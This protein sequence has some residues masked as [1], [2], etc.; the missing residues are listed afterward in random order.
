MTTSLDMKQLY[1]AADY[2]R[3][4]W[5]GLQ[6]GLAVVCGSGWSSVL[7]TVEIVDRIGYA[8]IPGLGAPGV[9]GHAGALCHVRHA[10]KDVLVFQGR[11]HFYEGE[12]WT[13]V[14]VPVFISLKCGVR[15]LLLTNSA[16]AIHP[17]FAPGDLMILTDHINQMGD[18]PLV[19]PHHPEFG[20]RFPDQSTVYDPAALVR[21]R[22][23][24]RQADV[25]VREGVYLATRGPVYETPA[26]VRACRL[27]GADA[28]GMSTI[29][30]AMLASAAGIRVGGLSCMTN[31]A[32]GILDQPLTH[33]EV[34]TT[35]TAA[36]PRMTALL[37][38]W[39]EQPSS[40]A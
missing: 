22:A 26:E 17:D 9:V 33:D 5:P 12:G 10:G 7:E 19:G 23:A 15:D 16:G 1:A 18:N 8:D 30:E 28:V 35:A 20:P 21:L 38:A 6:A 14:A 29:P 39:I 25:R 24:A 32:A 4:R 13:P 2:V 37:R 31:Y 36:M 11:R 34:T 3:N 40:R 27:L